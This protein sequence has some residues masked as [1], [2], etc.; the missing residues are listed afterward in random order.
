MAAKSIS[1]ASFLLLL[2]LITGS[3]PSSAV[4]PKFY[5]DDPIAVERD[6]QDA[7]AVRPWRIDLLA[8]V[9][10]N[11]FDRH[12]GRQL[13]PRAANVNTVDEVPDSSWFT[14]RL[15]HRPLTVAELVRGPDVSSGP[16]DGPWT[17]TAS[18]SDGV[19]PGFTIRDRA[20]VTWFLKFDP[21]GYRAMATGTE[22]MV[23]KLMWGLGYHVPE[24]HLAYFRPD[25]LEIGP[26][27]TF[28]TAVG[29]TRPM[30]P[31]DIA[32]LLL[33][34]N[35]EPD[36]SYRTLASRALDGVPLGGFRFD[37][38]R[39]DDPNDVI[40]HEHRRELRGYLVFCA[41]LNQ[42]DANAI[43]TL[44]MLI[45]VDG[46][47]VVRHH[48]IDFGSTMGSGGIAP[49]QYW[50]GHEY[51]IQGG[52]DREL[53][54]FGFSPPDWR[55]IDV[56][57]AKTVG[58]IP[59]HHGRFDPERWRPRVPNRAFAHARA[60]D[61]FWAARRVAAVT[62]EMLRAVVS[63]GQFDDLRSE[64]VLVRV[65][66]ERRDAIVRAYL[67]ALN[68][69]VNPQL[70]SAGLLTF[71]DAAVDAGVANASASYMAQ[72][73]AF[74][75][76]LNENRFLGE[77]SGTR[78]NLGSPVPLPVDDDAYLR[79]DVSAG[80]ARRSWELV[81]M[82]FRNTEQRGWQLIGLERFDKPD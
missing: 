62:D 4:S 20:G 74:D 49:R 55:T 47:A 69:I 3:L 44:D 31:A 75:N 65:L 79:V 21:P 24:N 37:G 59:L 9:L 48:L 64:E 10:I 71:Q 67:P 72:W 16:A 5:R 42:F 35:R 32:G 14:N 58:R 53:G 28:T 22:V 60:D 40:P 45:R 18:K 8:N 56:Y 2:I 19:T 36:G 46:R 76:A 39:P 26:E 15:G 82:F 41:W 54:T 30:R 13:A 70:T 78:S 61:K 11:L 68:S 52:I 17:V 23:T 57:E 1:A 34:A 50:E 43:N 29:R 51:V 77:S 12:G 7:S 6:H 38:T 80:S 63:A 27:A 81:T 33:R 73:F 25:R 66:R